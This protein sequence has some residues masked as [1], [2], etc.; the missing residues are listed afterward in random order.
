MK[1]FIIPIIAVVVIAGVGFVTGAFRDGELTEAEQRYNDGIDA[2]EAG[3]LEEAV[4][5]Y[6]EAIELD[7]NLAEAYINRSVDYFNL[8]RLEEALDDA[9][10]AIE[11]EPSD[12]SVLA[13]AYGMRALARAALGRSDEAEA[14]FANACELG[15]QEAC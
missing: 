11:L 8:G 6:T 7:P 4:T 5:L 14:D 3:R 9:T 13:S 15:L 10:R 2:D 1:R 12:V